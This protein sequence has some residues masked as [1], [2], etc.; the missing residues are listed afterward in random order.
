MIDVFPLHLTEVSFPEGHSQAGERGS[1]FGFALVH[2]D[3]VLLFD[4][5][6]GIGHA[7][8]DGWFRSK[9]YPLPEALRRHGLS[10]SDVVAVANSHLHFDHCGQ[11]RLFAGK[12]IYV[13]AREYRL[14]AEPD[15][16]VP[17]WVDFPGGAY[18]LLDGETE[19]LPGIRALPTPGHTPGH[20]SLAIEA[21]GRPILLAGQAVYT[22]DEWEGSNDPRCSGEPSAWDR[23][24]YADSVGRLRKLDPVRVLFA[25]DERIWERARKPRPEG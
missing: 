22:W 21:E 16:T 24:A 9:H 3:G 18:E 10:V 13:Q 20:E 11:N 23:E 8:I 19:L 7:E 4:T 14:V 2:Q 6:V 17:E 15:Y 12:P 5:G 25:H 1:I